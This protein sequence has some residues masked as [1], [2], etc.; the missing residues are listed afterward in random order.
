MLA[1]VKPDRAP[2]I[3]RFAQRCRRE[4]DRHYDPAALR[5]GAAA[6]VLSLAP[7]QHRTGGSGWRAVLEQ[8]LELAERWCSTTD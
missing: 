1:Q 2:V 6:V 8:R 4:F 5:I 7:G 3:E